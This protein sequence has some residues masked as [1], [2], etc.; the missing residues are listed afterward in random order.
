MLHKRGLNYPHNECH[1]LIL[2]SSL[3][4]HVKGIQEQDGRLIIG[5]AE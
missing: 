4:G 1:V 3:S 5:N 2:T